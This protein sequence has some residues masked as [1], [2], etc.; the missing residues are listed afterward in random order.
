[1]LLP[2]VYSVCFTVL[3]SLSSSVVRAQ[4]AV[5]QEQQQQPPLSTFNLPPASSRPKFRYWLPDASVSASAVQSDIAALASV[6]AGGLEFLGFYN[7]GFPPMSTDWS[8]YGFG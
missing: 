4:V 5:Q 8:I 3:H 7:Y 6:S 2:L 1:M